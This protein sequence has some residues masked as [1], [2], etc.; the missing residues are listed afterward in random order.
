[1]LAGDGAPHGDGGIEDLRKGGMGPFDLVLITLVRQAGRVQI[2]VAG[3]AE[4]TD[5][6]IVF[7][8]RFLNNLQHGGDA[9]ARYGGVLQDGGRLEPRQGR[10]GR[11][12]G[13]RQF[14]GLVG[15]LGGLE[16]GTAVFLAN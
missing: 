11:A 13:R 8:G 10:Q 2:T 9:A 12:A 6:H 1:M 15:I 16:E 4:G 5:G 14:E 3:M 7:F